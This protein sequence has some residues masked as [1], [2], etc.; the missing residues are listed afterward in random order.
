MTKKVILKGQG[1]I[2]KCESV[3]DQNPQARFLGDRGYNSV[4]IQWS[5][6]HSECLHDFFGKKGKF[7][8]SI[9]EQEQ[10]GPFLVRPLGGYWL[11]TAPS[12]LRD[13][14]VVNLDTIAIW[15]SPKKAQR[16]CAWLNKCWAERK[17]D[18]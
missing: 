9:I 2:T 10:Q 6:P 5:G 13:D 3:P 1:Y 4:T 17:E 12:L 15:D 8:L 16:I 14:N 7:E 11:V 18:V